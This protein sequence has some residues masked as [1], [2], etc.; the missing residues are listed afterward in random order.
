M[1]ILKRRGLIQV[2]FSLI[3]LGVLFFSMDFSDFSKLSIALDY[4][5]LILMTVL[6]FVSFLVRA[7]RWQILMDDG[8]RL[9]FSSAANSFKF[10]LVG[11]ALNIVMPAGAGDV[12]KSYFGYKWTGVKE[13]MFSVSLID[14]LIAIASISV[15]AIYSVIVTENWWFSLAAV[16][17]VMPFI[18]AFYSDKLPFIPRILEFLGRKTK[19][20]DF[21]EIIN[22]FDFKASTLTTSFLLS[23]VGWIFTYVA[24]YLCFYMVGFDVNISKVIAMGPVLTLGRLFP[25]TFNGVGSD[26]VLIVFLFSQDGVHKEEILVA[27]LLFR[28]CMMILPAIIGAYFLLSTKKMDLSSQQNEG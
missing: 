5:L 9:T 1:S 21:K 23:I 3:I 26:E 11:T 6:V 15:L 28:L 19:K 4:R 7:V 2:I 20:V 16:L 24:L 22:S 27:A 25:F 18:V 10:L 8:I 12:A 14:K 17:G 13:K